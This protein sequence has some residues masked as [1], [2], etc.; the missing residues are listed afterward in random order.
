MIRGLVL[1]LFLL[2]PASAFAQF[3]GVLRVDDPLHVFLLRQQAG[4]HLQ[5]VTLQHLPLSRYEALSYI[6]SID[7]TQL[8]RIDRQ[9]LSR[10]ADGYSEANIG[11]KKLW[12]RLYEDGSSFLSVEGADFR[13]EVDPV[14]Y[15]QAG[16]VLRPERDT[17][18]HSTF[19]NTRGVRVA[20]HIGPHL[21]FETRLEE[22]QRRDAWPAYARRTA[23]RLGGTKFYRASQEYDYWR[24]MGVV[25]IRTK[26]FEVRAGRDRN[27]WGDGMTSLFLSDYATEYDQLQIRTSVWRFQ[28]VNL[29]TAWT[30]IA[31]LHRYSDH[32][33]P[34]K[35]GALHSLAI[36]L[37]ARVQ[38]H[39]YEAVIFAPDYDDSRRRSFD[40]SYL[41]PI[42]FYRAV[43]IDRGSPDNMQIGGG[44]S[45]VP[46]RGLKTYL[47]GLLTEFNVDE[48][49]SGDGW[50]G[51]KWGWTAGLHYVPR[52]VAGL[53]VRIEHTR[54]RPFTYSH[55]DVETTFVHFD[56][57]LGHPAGQN[58]Y[59]Y[60]L[61][62]NYQPHLR[63]SAA[64]NASYTRRGRNP[65]GE[66]LGGNPRESYRTR[67]QD[68][69]H[70][71]GQG[72]RVDEYRV[73]ANAGY[74]L[75]P[76]MHLELAL[77]LE[78]IDDAESGTRWY[79]NPMLQLRWGIPF[80]SLR[81]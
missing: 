74:E 48:L 64:M 51:N 50:F 26:H 80:R 19:Q 33:M 25:G 15:L 75:L 53:D 57:P 27:R 12:P 81:Y 47:Q 65:D 44:I 68:H 13:F 66:N 23:P 73:E 6:D 20:G 2:I 24:A 70:F 41:N 78:H 21:F 30:D 7:V 61:R 45:W 62:L 9:L 4:G 42:I 63:W 29:F 67:L 18:H 52:Q 28:Y 40:L 32:T 46:T 11:L 71:I 77:Y 69:G 49:I 8:S 58:F 14:L 17:L 35:Y 31:S 59:D 60:A 55:R 54:V 36:D 1:V 37:P 3:E 10:Y 56:D 43:E 5:G 76:R 16:R 39:L 34:R 72:V 79:V 38:L 22:N